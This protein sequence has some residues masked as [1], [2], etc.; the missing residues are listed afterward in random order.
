MVIPLFDD[1]SVF[2]DNNLVS[3][4]NRLEAVSNDKASSTS[5]NGF[6][7]LLNLALCYRINIGSRFI[8]NQD[9]RVCQQGSGNGNQLLLSS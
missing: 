5:Y 3:I 4:E 9:L 1:L 6:H 8:Q 2:E 7:G